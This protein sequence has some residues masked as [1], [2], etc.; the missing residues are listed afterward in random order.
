MKLDI[1][2]RNPADKIERPKK[3]FIGD[4]YNLEELQTLFEK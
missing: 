2:P 4:C 3:Q 1:I